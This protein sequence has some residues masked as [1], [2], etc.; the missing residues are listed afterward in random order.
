MQIIDRKTAKAKGL[1]H[2]FTGKP[3]K[4]GH[5][6]PRWGAPCVGPLRAKPMGEVEWGWYTY[7]SNE[8]VAADL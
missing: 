6:M 7:P 1:T 8:T 4:R 2:Y 5:P 3:C